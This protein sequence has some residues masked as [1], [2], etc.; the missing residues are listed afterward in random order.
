MTAF[1]SAAAIT[2]SQTARSGNYT[3]S[4]ALRIAA[5]SWLV[6]AILGQLVFA[7][8]VMGFYGRAALQ[9]RLADWTKVL[10][11][12]HVP[13]DS[14]GNLMIWMHLIFTV[15]IILGGALQL[16][17][18]VRRVAPAIHRINGR[19]YLVAAA[20]LS[21]SG[22]IMLWTRGSV[23][24]VWQHIGTTVNGVLIIAFAWMA[25]RNA[26][27][28]Q[29]DVHRRWALRLFLAV[30]G[31]WF[32]RVGLMFWIVVNRGPAGFNPKTFDGPFLI[33]LSFAQYLLPLAVLELY[34]WAQRSKGT[35]PRIAVSALLAAATLVTATGIGA[36]SM[37]MWL[38]RL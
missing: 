16:I 31:V 33:F 8:Y 36:A 13:G 28:K 4:K 10:S 11:Y 17:P 21:A 6:V 22:I 32:F 23:G 15:F 3:A 25:W 30:S 7:A 5:I 18:R 2:G 35:T 20:V 14:F 37:I 27:A 19:A 12:G 1:S 9:G 29:L 26:V 34:F 38:P 24:G